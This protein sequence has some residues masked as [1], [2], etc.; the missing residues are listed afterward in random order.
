MT[1]YALAPELLDD[2][3]VGVYLLRE[4]ALILRVPS[5]LPGLSAS[6]AVAWCTEPGQRFFVCV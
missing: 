1:K 4:Q 6:M 5:V 2:G 3:V